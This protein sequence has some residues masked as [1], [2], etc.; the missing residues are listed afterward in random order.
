MGSLRLRLRPAIWLAL[1]AVLALALAPTVSRALAAANGA[2]MWTEVCTP[3][4]MKLQ[5]VADTAEDA[6]VAQ[7]GQI[8]QLEQCG[9]CALS[10]GAAPLPM[11]ASPALPAVAAAAALPALF[12]QA[13]R[14]LYAWRSAQPR[15]PPF[16]S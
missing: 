14:T 11:A 6:P 8:G 7:G 5:A 9:Y 13:P 16:F 12:L 2:S 3:A 4:G 15:A 1:I 10:A